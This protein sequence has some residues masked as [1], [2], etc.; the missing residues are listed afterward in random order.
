MGLGRT[1]A[2][3]EPRAGQVGHWHVVW[4]EWH[5]IEEAVG[6]VNAH[7]RSA[8]QR[9]GEGPVIVAG[10]T[11][12][13]RAPRVKGQSGAEKEIDF[14]DFNPGMKGGLGLADSKVPAHQFRRVVD[15]VEGKGAAFG[16]EGIDPPQPRT[17]LVEARQIRLVRKGGKDR[18]ASAVRQV[19]QPC[20]ERA[21]ET[22]RLFPFRP[23]VQSGQMPASS[24]S[25][26]G[27]ALWSVGNWHLQIIEEGGQYGR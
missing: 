24:E 26:I 2:H 25:Q 14:C 23:G 20:S 5:S 9:L 10:A 13:A 15:A 18:N 12:E 6:E 21:A 8:R 16:D 1:R 27:L 4:F 19:V 22:F 3:A 17:M 7:P 11:P